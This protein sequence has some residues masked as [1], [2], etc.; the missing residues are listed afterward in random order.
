MPANRAFQ[1]I[2]QDNEACV[3]KGIYFED[4]KTT[5]FPPANPPDIAP[6]RPNQRLYFLRVAVQTPNQENNSTK[7]SPQKLLPVVLYSVFSL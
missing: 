4:G 7:T 6:L 3:R 2:N 5:F 1:G